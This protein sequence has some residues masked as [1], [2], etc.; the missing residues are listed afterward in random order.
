MNMIL[1][2][3]RFLDMAEVLPPSG[4]L[5]KIFLKKRIFQIAPVVPRE[6]WNSRYDLNKDDFS[7]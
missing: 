4:F 1:I 5:V 2:D 6:Y 3:F 7:V